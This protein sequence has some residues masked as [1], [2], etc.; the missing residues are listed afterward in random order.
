MALTKSFT[1]ALAAALVLGA[2][3]SPAA[4]QLRAAADPGQTPGWTMTP[5]FVVSTGWDDNVILA[6]EGAETAGDGISIFTPTF[7]AQY[8]GRHNWIGLGYTGS[9]SAYYDLT[10]LNTYDQR[11]RVDTRHQLSRRVTLLLRDNFAAVPTTE[12]LFLSGVPFVRT[13]SKLNDLGTQVILALDEHMTLSGGYSFEWVEF[14]RDAPN[15]EFL[16]GGRTHVADASLRR[17][18]A[19]RVTIGADGSYRRALITDGGRVDIFDAQGY[20]SFQVTKALSI[21]GGAGFSRLRDFQRRETR[22]GPAWN[23]SLVQRVERVTASLGYVRSYVPAFGIGG[24]VQNQ[25]LTADVHMP[26]ARNRAYVQ[27][28]LSYRR[29]Q[30]LTP[31]EPDLKSLWFQSTI[32]YSVLRWFRLEGYYWRTQ[33]DSQQAGGRVNRDRIGVQA[34]T[35]L[36]MRIK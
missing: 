35:S 34:V 23:I 4:G 15:S 1:L 7:D 14:D 22:T 26:I 27:L 3:V 21:S 11:L 20:L 29:N 6:G 19:R 10:E 2:L 32:G 25:E 30:P 16:H 18:V 13:G 24:T 28:G 5:T 17:R 8:L 9:F 12:G 36:P 31:G 33:Q